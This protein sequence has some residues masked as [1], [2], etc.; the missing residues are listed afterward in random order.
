VKLLAT[1]MSAGLQA[2]G[3]G[4]AVAG[5]ETVEEKMKRR[6]E[7][8]NTELEK[9]VKLAIASLSLPTPRSYHDN[10]LQHVLTV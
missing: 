1:V 6:Q 3:Y 5:A 7:N 9:C 8:P 2:T 4:G 10:R